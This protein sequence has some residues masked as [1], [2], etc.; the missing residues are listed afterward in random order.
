[1]TTV[2]H[3]PTITWNAIAFRMVVATNIFALWGVFFQQRESVRLNQKSIMI[4]FR[5]IDQL[6][7]QVYPRLGETF[8]LTDAPEASEPKYPIKAL[9]SICG[10]SGRLRDNETN[11]VVQCSECTGTGARPIYEWEQRISCEACQSRGEVNG[12]EYK[13]CN[14][15]GW[16]PKYDLKASEPPLSV[17]EESAIR[18]QGYEGA[19]IDHIRDNAEARR[20]HRRL[21]PIR[22][23][24]NAAKTT[25]NLATGAFWLAVAAGVGCIGGPLLLILFCVVRMFSPKGT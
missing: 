5:A 24:E 20:E 22:P 4:Q 13:E 15:L 21:H 17:A 1:M 14:G 6:Q 3:K 16:I 11:A 18:S 23:I 2:P 9:C 10:G 25:G 7:K 8:V 19:L 12:E